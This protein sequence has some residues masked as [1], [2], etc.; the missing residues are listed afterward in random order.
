ML[1]PILILLL[2]TT[3]CFTQTSTGPPSAPPYFPVA[4]PPAPVPAL[5]TTTTT[6][7]NNNNKLTPCDPGE[8]IPGPTCTSFYMCV[9]WPNTAV[10][11]VKFECA[12]GTVFIQDLQT[13][14]AG[15]G[16]QCGALSPIASSS[17]AP[18]GPIQGQG[19][20]SQYQLDV[21]GVYECLEPGYYPDSSDCAKFY[22]C[23]NTMG[24]ILKGILFSCPKGYIFHT[25]LKRCASVAEVGE[26]DRASDAVLPT[27]E[28]QPVPVISADDLDQFFDS[29]IYWD[30][31]P[32]LPDLPQVV[33]PILPFSFSRGATA[34]RGS[35]GHGRTSGLILP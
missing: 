24:C 7:N 32:F 28:I 18:P 31:M 16:D 20:C 23:I 26:C 25:G 11:K 14:V 2:R 21:T 9:G 22:Q 30:V 35:I 33:V 29:Q 27:Y 5:A 1:L 12:P 13:C 3:V 8:L 17:P 15:D 10:R 6:T 4:F 19:S 34:D